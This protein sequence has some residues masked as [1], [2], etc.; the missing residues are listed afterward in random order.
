MEMTTVLVNDLQIQDVAGL[1]GVIF[2]FCSYGALQLGR[3]DGN[4]MK[5]SVLNGIAAILVLISLYKSF[6]LASALIQIIW[7][8]VSVVGI[9]RHLS[10]TLFSKESKLFNKNNPGRHATSLHRTRKSYRSNGT[11]V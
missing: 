5:Y 1:L 6:N 2:Y 8:T 3:L 7:I 4:S 10:A 9:C 11:Y